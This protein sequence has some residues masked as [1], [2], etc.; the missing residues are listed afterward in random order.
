[1]IPATFR[2]ALALC[3]LYLIF[4]HFLSLK[5]PSGGLPTTRR[6]EAQCAAPTNTQGFRTIPP[7]TSSTRGVTSHSL[8]PP[9]YDKATRWTPKCPYKDTYCREGT[10]CF[11]SEKLI[12]DW[13]RSSAVSNSR[14][15]IQ[16]YMRLAPSYA[17][18]QVLRIVGVGLSLRT[19]SFTMYVPFSHSSHKTSGPSLVPR[20][21]VA[22][23]RVLEDPAPLPCDP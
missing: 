1:M 11:R 22:F 18:L 20:R 16:G 10:L 19:A 23:T 8:L 5:S 14:V 17:G 7:V 12:F 13:F 2:H 3:V 6:R 21:G 15:Q 9:M 4:W